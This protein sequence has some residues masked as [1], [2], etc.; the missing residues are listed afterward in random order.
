VLLDRRRDAK[1]AAAVAPESDVLGIMLP[2]TPLHH[3]L[4]RDIDPTPLVMT[5]GNRSD[6]PIA[7]R[8]ADVTRQLSGIADLVLTHD[9]PIHRRADD[10]VVRVV[11]C[12][13]PLRRARGYAPRA[14]TLP[15]SLTRPTLALGGHLKAVF[16]LG[17]SARAIPSSHFGDLDHYEAYRA[18]TEGIDQFQRLF[19][20]T[21]RRF[22]HDLH[23]DYAS[24]RFAL[25]QARATGIE[26]LAVQHHHAHMASCLAEHGLDGPAIGVCFDG[27]GLGT[28]GTIWGG[29][30]LL[31][32]CRDVTRVGHLGAVAMPGGERAMREPWRMA[33]AHLVNAGETIGRSSLARRIDAGSIRMVERMVER[34]I[35]AP[36]TSSIG[37]LFDAVAALIGVCDRATFEGQAAMRLESLAASATSD[38]SYPVDLLA[39]RDRLIV[40]PAPIISG[41]V[42]D[43]AAGLAAPVIAR[44]FHSTIADMVLAVCERVRDRSGVATVVLT[45]GVFVNAILA[46]GVP[47]RLRGAGFSV[48][49]HETMPPNDGGLCLG[50]L[51]IAAARD[52]R[53]ADACPRDEAPA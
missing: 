32:D 22:V 15:R 24:T 4:L 39:D 44:R 25:E 12:A 47:Q 33:V 13:L 31:G 23:P 8:D 6:E 7:Y 18:W 48:F 34:T 37:R 21:P 19:H 45:G 11:G 30:F 27:A 17:E 1:I 42:R 53:R 40:D 41:V 20:I 46:R 29:E 43:A 9:R 2:Y 5:S 26:L 35:N 14:L 52:E 49:I 10:S 38:G 3:L 50:Q 28:D 36:A 16:A 51:A